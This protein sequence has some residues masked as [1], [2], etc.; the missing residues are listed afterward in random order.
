MEELITSCRRNPYL[1][2][3][4]MGCMV[5]YQGRKG[6]E[7]NIQKS[8]YGRLC[9]NQRFVKMI[10]LLQPAFSPQHVLLIN[11]LIFVQPL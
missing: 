11:S 8:F 4:E 5:P 3:T 7:H 9:A 1:S 10:A 6:S 2:R